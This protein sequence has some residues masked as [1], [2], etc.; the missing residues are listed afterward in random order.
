[1]IHSIFEFGDTLVR[2]VMRP[3]ID[4]I[5]VPAT[6]TINEA[7]RTRPVIPSTGRRVASTRPAMPAPGTAAQQAYLWSFNRTRLE[8][9]PPGASGRRPAVRLALIPS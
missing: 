4:I 8:L 3:R 1:M 6:A 2:E 9:K 7:M 5:G